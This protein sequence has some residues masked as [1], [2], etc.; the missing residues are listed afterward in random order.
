MISETKFFLLKYHDKI[1]RFSKHIQYEIYYLRWMPIIERAKHLSFYEF[2]KIMI[3]IPVLVKDK[4]IYDILL[5][6]K[7]CIL[8]FEKK[9][10]VHSQEPIALKTKIKLFF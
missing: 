3:D 9:Y 8:Q 4:L 2:D 5:M 6:R 10:I 1:S 7:S